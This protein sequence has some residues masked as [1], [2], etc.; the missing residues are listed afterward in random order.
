M[1]VLSFEVD[2]SLILNGLEVHVLAE[3]C[4]LEWLQNASKP[5]VEMIWLNNSVNSMNMSLQ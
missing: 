2:F 1:A 5:I 3:P 4:F